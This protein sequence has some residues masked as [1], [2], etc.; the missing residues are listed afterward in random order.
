[1]REHKSPE[2]GFCVILDCMINP[3]VIFGRMGNRMFQ[4]AYLY[5]QMKRG[6]IPDLFVQDPKFFEEC[7]EDIKK[8]YGEGVGLLPYTGIHLR[9]GANPI[10]PNEPRYSENPFYY[11]LI[12]TGYYI[13]ALEHFPHGKFI[14]FSD[15]MEF[16]KTY[17]VGDR[18]AFDESENDIEAFN[19]LAS[20]QNIIMANSS[21]SWWAGYLCPHVDAKILYPNVWFSDNVKR[22]GFP[23]EWT[24][25][26]V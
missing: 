13:K 21:W 17:F 15:D 2:R 8:L 11:K 4:G 26:E 5:A 10:N 12:E 1:M 24:E 6:E 20:C 25:I 18:F 23:K 14:I 16:A 7:S 9:V 22:V 3:D 19:K